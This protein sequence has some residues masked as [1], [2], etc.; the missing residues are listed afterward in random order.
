MKIPYLISLF[1]LFSCSTS[2]MEK[3]ITGM[4]VIDKIEVKKKVITDVVDFLFLNVLN[5]DEDNTCRFPGRVQIRGVE[6]KGDWTVI[7]KNGMFYLKI[8]NCTDQFFNGSYRIIFQ[9][10]ESV[11][12]SS[13]KLK[14]YCKK[15]IILV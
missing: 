9:N 12:F 4:W 11:I 6:E 13:E 14:L 1:L 15:V 5:L 10:S 2:R 7:N 3:K 8:T